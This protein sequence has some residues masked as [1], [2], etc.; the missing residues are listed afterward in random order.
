MRY[1]GLLVLLLSLAVVPTAL[2]ESSPDPTR[3]VAEALCYVQASTLGQSAFAAKYGAGDAGKKACMAAMQGTAAK[4]VA[5]CKAQ[6]QASSEAFARCLKAKVLGATTA[7]KPVVTPS[8]DPYVPKVAETLCKSEYLKTGARA[9]IEKYGRADTLRACVAARTAD[10]KALVYAAGVACKSL[11]SS[12]D[13][14]FRC[15]VGRL[16]TV[17]K[18]GP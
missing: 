6:A 7:P 2:G 5:D 15:V 8:L 18:P 14:F 17:S 4:A 10:A 1:C 3:S 16:P 12:K 13:A 9:F 11:A